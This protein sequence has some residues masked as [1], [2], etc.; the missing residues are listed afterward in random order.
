MEIVFDKDYLRELYLT[1]KASGKK[2]RFQP[3]VIAKYRKTVDLL[4]S[5][6]GIEDL[7]RYHSLNYEILSGDKK[8]VE[9]VRVTDQYRVE[10]KTSKVVSET[11][12][13]ICNIIEL[14]NHYK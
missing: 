11:V 2:Y 14:S 8:G 5:V 9:S 6:S 10:F 1:G 13:T 7:Y 3:N 4:E 12:I